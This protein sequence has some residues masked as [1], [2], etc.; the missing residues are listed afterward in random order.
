MQ[1][2]CPHKPIILLSAQ[3][4]NVVINATADTNC[5][6]EFICLW[7][8]MQSAFSSSF[9]DNV[10]C[11]VCNTTTFSGMTVLGKCGKSFP[12]DAHFSIDAHLSTDA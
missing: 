7:N 10:R 9:M 12:I 6:E 1:V 3:N 8:R 4:N 2:A 5:T 11:F